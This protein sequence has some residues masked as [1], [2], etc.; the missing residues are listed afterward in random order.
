MSY[1]PTTWTTGDTITASAMNKIEQGIASAGN[2]MR[3]MILAPKDFNSASHMF[4]A[5]GYFKQINNRWESMGEGMKVYWFANQWS[6]FQVI[7]PPESSGVKVFWAV[8][9]PLLNEVALTFAGDIN[10]TPITVYDSSN[11]YNGYELTGA[12]YVVMEAT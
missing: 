7:A 8:Y 2:V 9:A 4:G 10:S 1:T 3:G 6:S 5:I 12:A 11:S